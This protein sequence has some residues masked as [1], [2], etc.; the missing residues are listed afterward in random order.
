MSWPSPAA[1]GCVIVW[2]YKVK[3]EYQALFEKTYS[4]TGEWALF[5]RKSA[6]YLG[7]EL[8][9]D[10]HDPQRYITSDYWTS[11]ADY[12][13]FCH[14]YE[15][16]YKAIDQKCDAWTVEETLIGRFNRP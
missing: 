6:A 10:A 15:A 5:F 7:T 11:E 14:Q 13:A 12:D 2:T 9:Q 3:A 8:Y 1:T 4:S 16:E